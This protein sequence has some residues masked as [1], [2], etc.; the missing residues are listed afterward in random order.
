[1]H[2]LHLTDQAIPRIH[3]CQS[4]WN[5]FSEIWKNQ[6]ATQNARIF[7]KKSRKLSGWK[8]IIF[9]QYWKVCLSNSPDFL[10]R[11]RK[12][13]QPLA[14]MVITASRQLLTFQKTGTHHLIISGSQKLSCKLTFLIEFLKL[15]HFFIRQSIFFLM[16]YIS[17]NTK[18]YGTCNWFKPPVKP[19]RLTSKSA[20][21][22]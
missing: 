18:K 11:T 3:P 1:M 6:N 8:C 12:R 19:A 10:R 9:L 20:S 14:D 22:A 17:R 4:D 5:R 21:P 15:P 7:T 16:N 2:E 13:L